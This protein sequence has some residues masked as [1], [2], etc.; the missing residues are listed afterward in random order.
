[1]ITPLLEHTA[2]ELLGVYGVG[3]DTA[4]P[5]VVAAGDNPRALAF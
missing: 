5:F 4:A 3:I 1:M 2:P